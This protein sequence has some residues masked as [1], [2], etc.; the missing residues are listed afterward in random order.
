MRYSPSAIG[1]VGSLKKEGPGIQAE[2]LV[3][4]RGQRGALAEVRGRRISVEWCD[5]G[6]NAVLKR[7]AARETV[8]R[9]RQSERARLVAEEE[10]HRV[11]D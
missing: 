3:D 11:I 1:S 5:F 10:R 4:R 7:G 2:R 8:Q 9:V 6:A